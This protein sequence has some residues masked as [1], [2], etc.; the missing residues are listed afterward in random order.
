MTNI[1]SE[2]KNSEWTQLELLALPRSGHRSLFSD[3]KIFIV[4]SGNK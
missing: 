4:G 1:V 2:Y 3:N